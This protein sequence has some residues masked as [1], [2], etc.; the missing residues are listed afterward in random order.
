VLKVNFVNECQPLVDELY[1]EEV[2][3]ARSL[4]TEG[5]FRVAM[6]IL[7]MNFEW[8]RAL[9]EAEMKRRYRIARALDEHGCY[10]PPL[11]RS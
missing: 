5:R 2:L 11:S 10:G 7:E 4:G 6:E 3:K 9:G 1:R 8:A